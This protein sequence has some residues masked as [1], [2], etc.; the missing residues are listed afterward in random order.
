MSQAVMSRAQALHQGG[1]LDEA[2]ALYEQTLA[3]DPNNAEALYLLGYLWFQKGELRRALELIGRAIDL[4]PS[5]AGYRYNRALILQ[6]TNLLEAAAVD[7]QHVAN[8]EPA[9]L[10]AW[11]G[12]GETQLRLGR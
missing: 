7:F 11:E 4:Q 10:G 3:A 1:R 6:Q 8:A 9:D 12:L 5:N 2:C